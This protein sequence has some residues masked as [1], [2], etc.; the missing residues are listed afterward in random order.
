[1]QQNSLRTVKTGEFSAVAGK[2]HDSQIL[3]RVPTSGGALGPIWFELHF[4]GKL[5]FPFW[6]SMD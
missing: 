4:S 5:K 3:P 6:M 1:M 2:D